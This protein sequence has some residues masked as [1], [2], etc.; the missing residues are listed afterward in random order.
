MSER[1]NE[2]QDSTER[3]TAKLKLLIER[4]TFETA[5]LREARD[6]VQEHRRST[7][8]KP[9]DEAQEF[10]SGIALNNNGMVFQPNAQG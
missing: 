3:I 1:L 4:G 2:T 9:A 5:T 7:T 6:V 8:V 10:G